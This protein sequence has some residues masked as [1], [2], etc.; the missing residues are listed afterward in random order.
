[1]E[2]VPQLETLEVARVP[3]MWN[4]MASVIAECCRSLTY[5][6]YVPTLRCHNLTSLLLPSMS[7]NS[8]V[9]DEGIRSLAIAFQLRYLNISE[10][11]ITDQAVVSL[12]KY[13]SKLNTLKLRDCRLL[14]NLSLRH[15]AHLPLLE[16]LDMALCPKVNQTCLAVVVL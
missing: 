11:N 6:K 10:C 12:C 13:S 14:T 5:L 9:S 7:Q 15:I 1:M 4:P 8:S 3:G 16:D 2:S